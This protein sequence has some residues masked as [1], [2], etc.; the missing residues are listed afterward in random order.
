MM[1]KDNLPIENAVD[2]L[3]SGC[4]INFVLGRLWAERFVEA[5]LIHLFLLRL[6]HGIWL[7]FF[8]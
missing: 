2:V 6:E 1:V 3:G 7:S 4:S 5:V 8:S